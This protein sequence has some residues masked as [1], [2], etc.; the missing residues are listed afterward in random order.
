MFSI[1]MGQDALVKNILES[2]AFGP[3][4]VDELLTENTSQSEASFYHVGFV[5]EQLVSVG[6]M[7]KIDDGRYITSDKGE[8][9]LDHINTT[10]CVK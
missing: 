6:C 1:K 8:S 4:T 7:I 10:Y 5:L 3:R 9:I 2:G